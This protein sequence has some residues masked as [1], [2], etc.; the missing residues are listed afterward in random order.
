MKHATTVSNPR[1][2]TPAVNAS[3]VGTSAIATYSADWVTGHRGIGCDRS[4]PGA[5]PVDVHARGPS[6]L[7]IRSGHLRQLAS[8]QAEPE[9][10]CHPTGLA[11]TSS[12]SRRP[13]SPDALQP[14]L[15]NCVI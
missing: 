9:S 14:L 15:S 3:Y 4:A 1:I 6:A 12:T 5:R 8:V 2:A 13:K 11:S 7:A 10:S